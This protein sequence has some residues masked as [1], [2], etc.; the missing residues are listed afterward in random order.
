MDTGVYTA[1]NAML[2]Q[3]NIETNIADNLSNMET[4]GYKAHQG[5]LQDFSSVLAGTSTASDN[6]VSLEVNTVGAVGSAPTVRDYGLNLSMGAPKHTGSP[7]DVMIDGNAFF[8]VQSGTQT[9]LTRNGNFQRAA[10]GDLITSQGYR[11]LDSN[12]K[13]IKVPAGNLTI[14]RNGQLSVDGKAGV[15]LGLAQVPT[16]QPLSELGGGYYVGP[17]TKVQAGTSGVAVLQGYLEGSN[18]DMTA[19]TTNMISA[20]RAYEAA[21]KMLQ[22]EDA[23]VGLAV[24]D[25]GKVST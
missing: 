22:I 25:L 6:T 1:A 12:G 11:V 24:S 5:V 2:A 4:P 19:Q 13:V 3:F 21:S 10:D 14:S 20:Q 17:G 16:G 7:L 23:T 18:V 9:L 15:T 8:T